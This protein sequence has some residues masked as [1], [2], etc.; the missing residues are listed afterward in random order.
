[1]AIDSWV[2]NKSNRFEPDAYVDLEHVEV[3]EHEA[4]AA[5]KTQNLRVAIAPVISPEKSLEAYYDLVK[6]LGEKVGRPT[7]LLTGDDYSAV[8]NLMRLNQCDMALVCT[9]SFILGERNFD[10]KLLAIPEIYGQQ[11]YRSYVIAPLSS[12][13]SSLLDFR[14]RRFASSDVLSTS[15]WLYPMTWL[16][17]KGMDLESFFSK[18]LITGSHDRS[19]QAVRAGVVDGAAVDSLVFEQLLRK[20]PELKNEVRIIQQSE[21]FG[22]PPLVIPANLP[23]GTKDKLRGALLGM[24][25]DSNGKKVLDALSIDRFVEAKTESYES[26]RQLISDWENKP[27]G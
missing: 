2:D 24:H 11:V 27:Q 1:M 21:T 3:S 5:N 8:N 23:P 18:H 7:V 12:T 4:V 6:H 19:I 10:M 25:E 20:D 17:S 9:Y 15:G 22:M 16:K 26:V 14:H 13:C